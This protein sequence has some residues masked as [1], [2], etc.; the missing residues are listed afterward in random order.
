MVDF[1]F[2]CSIFFSGSL[3]AD[4]VNDSLLAGN[5]AL[6]FFEI[7]QISKESIFAGRVQTDDVGGYQLDRGFQILLDG[8]PEASSPPSS[9]LVEHSLF[10]WGLC[11]I[12]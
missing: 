2:V 6:H 7:L 5:V 9:K 4:D 11:I 10:S 8:Y 1:K 12:V 3:L